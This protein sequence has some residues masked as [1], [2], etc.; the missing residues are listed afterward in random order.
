MSRLRVLIAVCV[1][2]RCPDC[3]PVL[4]DWSVEIFGPDKR[5]HNSRMPPVA[6]ATPAVLARLRNL[7]DHGVQT[8]LRGDSVYIG[9]PGIY[10]R[11]MGGVLTRRGRPT[12]RWRGRHRVR[13]SR[14]RASST[15]TPWR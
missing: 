5:K 8:H 10:L 7:I 6:M 1:E 4:N 2:F 11:A 9:H 15:T 13:R 3:E 12:M 14:R